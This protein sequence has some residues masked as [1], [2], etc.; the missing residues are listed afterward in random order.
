MSTP[1]GGHSSASFRDSVFVQL[2]YQHLGEK[3]SIDSYSGAFTVDQD[4]KLDQSKQFQQ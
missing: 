2:L 1:F 4:E 3:M